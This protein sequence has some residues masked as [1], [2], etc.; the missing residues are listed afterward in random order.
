MRSGSQV[1][2]ETSRREAD[3]LTAT[4]REENAA[5]SEAVEQLKGVIASTREMLL[6]AVDTADGNLAAVEAIPQTAVVPAPSP[7]P[8]AESVPA[9]EAIPQTAV[10]PA[11]SPVPEAE[12][13]P[14]VEPREEADADSKPV[15]QAIE[16]DVAEPATVDDA[17]AAQA[18]EP[19]EQPHEVADEAAGAVAEA[20]T[21]AEA[22]VE[23]E[24]P[25][26][27]DAMAAAEEPDAT[28]DV[29]PSML[30]DESAGTAE[31]PPASS[32]WVATDDAAE[33]ETPPVE[34]LPEE[35][36]R[37]LQQLRSR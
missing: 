6:D 24:E 33:G 29:H 17:P 5:M 23:Q 32:G 13:V 18:L 21:V 2:I 1:L 20:E 37:L 16:E 19:V 26:P 30:G 8:E 10:V 11:A 3:E 36:D 34:D 27:E 7:V 25:P 15:I 31:P 4:A 35:V 12:S 22:V 9:V 28:V 14:A